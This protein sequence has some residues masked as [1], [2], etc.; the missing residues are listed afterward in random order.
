MVP[1]VTTAE[2]AKQVV[3]WTRFHPLG[4]RALDGGNADASFCQIPI[5]EYIEHSNTERLI[6]LQI[7]SPEG[8]QNVEEIAEVDGY[9]FLLF[10]PGDFSH[11]IGEAGN[12]NHPK[13]LQ[14]RRRVAAAATRN[15]KFAM[16]AGLMGAHEEL[17]EEGYRFFNI[18]ADVVG[19]GEFFK[20]A[21]K[22]FHQSGTAHLVSPLPISQ[23]Y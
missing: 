23:V 1:H 2:E 8:V 11:L 9:D 3:E 17:E 18:G 5:N 13:V 14:A 6:I 22:S 12:L 20:S 7:E 15:G 16:S 19:M 10:G 4:R 21:L